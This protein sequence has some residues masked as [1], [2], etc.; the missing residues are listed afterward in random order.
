MNKFTS[1]PD[2]IPMLNRFKKTAIALMLAMSTTGALAQTDSIQ[3]ISDLINANRMKEAYELAVKS[4]DRLGDPAF[5]YLYGLAAVETGHAAQGVLA[6][7]RVVSATPEN[8]NARLELARAYFILGEDARSLTEFNAVLAQNPPQLVRDNIGR[9]IDAIRARQTAYNV[10]TRGFIETGF[11]RDSNVNAGPARD[12]ALPSGANFTITDDQ[13]VGQATY[14]VPYTAGMSVSVPVRPGVIASVSAA[15]DGRHHNG[16]VLFQQSS[17]DFAAGLS[18]IDEDNLY[19]ATLGY[20]DLMLDSDRYRHSLNLGGEFQRQIDQKNIASLFMQLSELGYE[21]TNSNRDGRSIVIGGNW[22]HAL[23]DDWA[24]QLTA[25]LFAGRDL[26]GQA[27]HDYSRNLVG[28]RLGVSTSP[29]ASW[30]LSAGLNYSR[31]HYFSADQSFI[32]AINQNPL[33]LAL[34][35]PEPALNREDSSRG[36]DLSAT[37]LASRNLSVRTDVTHSRNESNIE[38]YSYRRTAYSVKARYEFF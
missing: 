32:G 26:N 38:V 12:F 30:V 24:T 2:L 35:G 5:D 4:D 13:A 17:Y 21:G 15:F 19:R 9:F 8:F 33:A 28:T 6:L 27:R 31:S 7:E 25:A 14:Y 34:N 16:G 22:R 10:T 29:H 20:T 11:G 1:S 36:I 18:I 37:W 3:T 23:L